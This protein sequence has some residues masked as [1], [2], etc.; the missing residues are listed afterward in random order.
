MVAGVIGRHGD[1][2]VRRVGKGHR[3]GI[4]GVTAHIPKMV[5]VIV[6]AS[7][8]TVDLARKQTARVS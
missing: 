7:I 8:Q 2:V 5:V 3:T 1:R 6:E 4:E